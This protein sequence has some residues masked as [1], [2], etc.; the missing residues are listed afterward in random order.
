MRY[1]VVITDR[2]S[3]THAGDGRPWPEGRTLCGRPWSG[4]AGPDAR[5]TCALCT[6]NSRTIATAVRTMGANR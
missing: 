3:N 5:V 4:E 1:P 2:G 6:R